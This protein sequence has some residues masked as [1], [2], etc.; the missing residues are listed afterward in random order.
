M[1]A[2]KQTTR[3]QGKKRKFSKQLAP[4]G[5]IHATRESNST[6][7]WR[8]TPEKAAVKQT[9]K[10]RRNKNGRAVNLLEEQ[11]YLQVRENGEGVLK[12]KSRTPH[13]M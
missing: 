7:I 3:S 13:K 10:R 11:L 9:T 6:H 4:S 5:S 12:K 8:E 2:V 1:A